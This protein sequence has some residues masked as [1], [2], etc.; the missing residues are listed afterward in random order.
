MGAGSLFGE[1]GILACSSMIVSLA[2]LL[3]SL[4]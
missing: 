4:A 3:Q 1:F 2:G